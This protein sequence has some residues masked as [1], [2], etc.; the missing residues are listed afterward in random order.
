MPVMGVVPGTMNAAPPPSRAEPA[1]VWKTTGSVSFAAAD[2]AE[3]WLIEASGGLAS[4]KA[5]LVSIGPTGAS[6]V[7]TL[8][9]YAYWPA[10][11]KDYVYLVVDKDIGRV[12]KRPPHATKVLRKGEVWPM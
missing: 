3:V 4:P 9:G 6:R 1:L 2:G 11:D 5:S 7:V 10:A 8:P 12:E